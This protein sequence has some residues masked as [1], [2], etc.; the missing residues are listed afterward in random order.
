[1]RARD[2]SFHREVHQYNRPEGH[3]LAAERMPKSEKSHENVWK[4]EEGG[5]AGG[6]GFLGGWSMGRP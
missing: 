1:M 5:N 3:G 2:I 6:E 4:K